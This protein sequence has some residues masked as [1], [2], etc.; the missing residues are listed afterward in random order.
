[1]MKK[2]DEWLPWLEKKKKQ[3]ASVAD[4]PC[5]CVFL[6]CFFNFEELFLGIRFYIF[7]LETF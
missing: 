3:V 5:F 6:S 4:S 7:A 2:K 1:M